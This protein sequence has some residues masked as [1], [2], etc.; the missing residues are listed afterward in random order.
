MILVGST[1]C[2]DKSEIKNAFMFLDRVSG[3]IDNVA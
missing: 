3:K 1:V 2:R